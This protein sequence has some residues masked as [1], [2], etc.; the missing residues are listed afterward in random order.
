[1]DN[2]L[3]GLVNP[4][5]RHQRGYSNTVSKYV[6][7]VSCACGTQCGEQKNSHQLTKGQVIPC[8]EQMMHFKQQGQKPQLA[9]GKPVGYL[10]AWPRS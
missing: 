5:K 8:Q 1:M 2:H 9:E 4:V 3:G 7:T 6:Y 10:Q